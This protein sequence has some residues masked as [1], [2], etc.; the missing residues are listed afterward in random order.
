METDTGCSPSAGLRQLPGSSSWER[1]TSAVLK[2]GK[3]RHAAPSQSRDGSCAQLWDHCGS[4]ILNNPL[5]AMERLAE[6]EGKH[7]LN[8]RRQSPVHRLHTARAAAGRATSLV[9]RGGAQNPPGPD[10]T[11]APC[12]A[13]IW[14]VWD[15]LVF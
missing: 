14:Q 12:W 8:T 6:G 9:V 11:P 5:V 2:L 10:P 3:Q 15:S 7:P 13:F 4:A 1:I